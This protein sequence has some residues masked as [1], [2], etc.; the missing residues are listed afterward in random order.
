MSLSPRGSLLCLVSSLLLLPPAWAED[1]VRRHYS[2]ASGPLGQSLARF[3]DQAGVELAFDTRLVEAFRAPA[4]EGDYGVH[5]GLLELLKGTPLILVE[6]QGR[7]LVK[8]AQGQ[9]DE[10]VLQLDQTQVSSVREGRDV[11]RFANPYVLSSEQIAKRPLNNSNLTDLLRSHP[12]V[13][14]SNSSRSG[15]NQG[16][17]R[18]D[19]ISIHGARA[20]QGLFAMDGIRMNNDLDPVDPGNG[21]TQAYG[22]SSEQGFFFDSRLIDSI[23]V[24]DSNISARYSG[25][26]GGVV[27]STS[28]SWRGGQGGNLY[29]R[30]SDSSWNH[31][32]TDSRLDFRSSENNSA[33]P[34]RFQPKYQKTDYGF[35]AETGLLDNLGLVVSGSRRDSKI[36]MRD[37]GGPA[38]HIEGDEIID[39]EYPARNRLQRRQ[40][41][42]LSAKL[43]WYASAQTTVHWSVMSSAYTETMFMNTIANSGYDTDHDGLASVLKVEHQLPWGRL[44]LTGSYRQMQDKRASD[45]DYR[46]SVQDYSDWSNP[47]SYVYGGIGSLDSRQDTTELSVQFSADRLVLGGVG[48]SLVTGAGVNRVK[49]AFDRDQDY[50]TATFTLMG[51]TLYPSQVDAFFA[52]RASTRYTSYHAFVE[53]AMDWGR[54]TVRPGL[55]LDRDDFVERSNLA[56]R[57]S[58]SFDAFGNGQTLFKL[59][60]NRYYGSSML[61]YA[62]YG[63]QNAGLK[64]CYYDCFP[65]QDLGDGSWSNTPDYEGLESLKT[66]Y[67]DEFMIGMDQRWGNSLW[68]LQY[69]KRDHGDE[70]RSRPK[71]PGTRDSSRRS[72][73]EFINDSETE[74]DN[75]YLRVSTVEPLDWAQAQHTLG[76]ALSWQRTRSDTAL[77]LGYTDTDLT[78]NLDASQAWFKGRVIAAK[79]L[80]AT[81]FNAPWKLNLDWQ[82]DWSSLGLTLF[83]RLTMESSRQQVYKHDSGVDGYYTLPDSNIR[84]RKYSE[85]RI[86]S[87][88]RWDTSVQWKPKRLHGLGFNA[89]IN[90]LL[91]TRNQSDTLDWQGMTY[92]VYQPGRQLWLGVSYDF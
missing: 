67:S 30:H 42:N 35:W 75:V 63:A 84:V 6:S 34:S 90:N 56:P 65:V 25:F 51:E 15:L 31:T 45:L 22:T 61:T 27:D 78:M 87:L 76:A 32:F 73:K 54:L 66:P 29:S 2:L 49:A 12:V 72:I 10:K 52:S 41:D 16:E 8:P 71:Y 23:E 40:S 1:N 74:S 9:A 50:Y 11:R 83:N 44:D 4:L 79:D 55:R 19:S 36:P 33:N 70:V 18:P 26:T 46:I 80:P 92:K 88:W 60:L 57:L 69:V 64:H 37:L 24:H 20:Y 53:D 17:I 62:L 47:S 86:G 82:A 3:A 91:N 48:H 58:L 14:F 59:G 68:Q 7:Y 5:D 43:S 81:D 77:E 39:L 13:Q 85:A 21:V 38:F 89:E 28:R